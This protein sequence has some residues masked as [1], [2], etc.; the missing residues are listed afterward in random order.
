MNLK[1][2]DVKMLADG[3]TVELFLYGE[4]GTDFFFGDGIGAKQVQDAL[5]RAPLAEQIVVHVNSPGGSVWEGMAIRSILAANKANVTFEIEGLCASACTCAAMGADTIRMHAGSAMMI[6]EGQKRTAGGILEHQRGVAQLQNV[7]DGASTLYAQRCGK[8]KDEMLQLMAAET[9]LTPEQAVAMGLADEVVSGKSAAPRMAFDLS[10]FGYRNMPPELTAVYML[11]TT[12]PP[13]QET[14][15]MSYARI[16]MALSLADTADEAAVMSALAALNTKLQKRDTLLVELRSMTQR[17]SD[18]ELVGYVRGLIESAAKV[19]E[20]EA[21]L[22]AA[23]K[24]NED[25]ERAAVIAADAADP[26]G[27]KLTPAL[28]KLWEKKP[29]SELK[30]YLEA[31]PH[32]VQTTE[33]KHEPNSGSS[34]DGAGASVDGAELKVLKHNEKAYEELSPQERHNLWVSNRAKFDELRSNYQERRAAS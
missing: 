12:K 29:V 16:A 8:S 2:F 32:Q 9:W 11:A 3:K 34:A 33:T 24:R 22:E 13:A 23:D 4:I 27:R 6:H 26:K 31:A 5:Q 18:D 21:K 20:L 17:A 19:P 25:A 28:L 7:N 15:T 14:T 30:A 10:V 1:P